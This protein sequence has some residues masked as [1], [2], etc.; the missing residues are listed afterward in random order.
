MAAWWP[1]IPANA[2][3]T[4]RSMAAFAVFFRRA[5]GFMGSAPWGRGDA[6]VRGGGEPPQA[7]GESP[8][9][10]DAGEEYC[11]ITLPLILERL[12]RGGRAR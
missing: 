8:P 1:G 5:S 12:G 3:R 9:A 6:T 11:D 2:S 4:A 7:A 10:D